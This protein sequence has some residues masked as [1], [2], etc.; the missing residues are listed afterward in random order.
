MRT[1][2]A[3]TPMSRWYPELSG[4]YKRK[5]STYLGIFPNSKDVLDTWNTINIPIIVVGV[6][7]EKSPSLGEAAAFLLVLRVS[8]VLSAHTLP[9]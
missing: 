6:L 5:H 1:Y 4:W 8:Q 9:L 2:L 7:S 3:D